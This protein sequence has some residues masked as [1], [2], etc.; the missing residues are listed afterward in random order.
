VSRSGQET[1][2]D[3]ARTEVNRSPGSAQ[4]IIST[5]EN[6]S[7]GMK[8]IHSYNLRSKTESTSSGT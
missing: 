6:A 1:E 5:Q 3:K 4:L 2:R 7:P 8:K